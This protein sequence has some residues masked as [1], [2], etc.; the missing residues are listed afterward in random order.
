MPGSRQVAK[1]FLSKDLIFF[2]IISCQCRCIFA[3]I[4]M[5]WYQYHCENPECTSSIVIFTVNEKIQIP[6]FRKVAITLDHFCEYK[7]HI[8]ILHTTKQT[9]YVNVVFKV[10]KKLE[11]IKSMLEQFIQMRQLKFKTGVYYFVI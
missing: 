11:W 3:I 10:S 7:N 9:P 6:T 1:A 2:S 8:D 4:C 5:C